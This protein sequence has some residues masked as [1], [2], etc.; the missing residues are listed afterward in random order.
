MPYFDFFRAAELRAAFS[1]PAWRQ[2]RDSLTLRLTIGALVALVAS[3]GVTTWV[4]VRYAEHETE[5]RERDA[6]LSENQAMARVLSRRVLEY[7]RALQLG[8]Q[9]LDANH[10]ASF[11]QID[12]ALK[13]KA[14]LTSMFTNI[15]VADAAG[16]MLAYTD[17]GRIVHPDIDLSERAYF[18]TLLRE[19]R[20]I[21]ST[22]LLGRISGEAS[23]VLAQPLMDGSKVTGV[24]GGVLRLGRRDLLHDITDSLP[25]ADALHPGVFVVVSDALGRILAHPQHDQVGQSLGAERHLDQAFAQWVAM[26]RPLEPTGLNLEQHED[27]VTIA[28][29]PGPDWI[30]WRAYPKDLMHAPLEMARRK[31]WEWTGI[32]SLAFSLMLAAYVAWQLSPLRRLRHRVKNLLDGSMR[33]S[34]GWPHGSGEVGMLSRTLRYVAMELE[35]KAKENHDLIEQLGSVMA[36]APMG[37]AFVRHGWLDMVN[38][39][40]SNL[41]G[42]SQSHLK[43]MRAE[44]LLP[45]GEA[46]MMLSMRIDAAFLAGQS[47]AGDG[48]FLRGDGT[49][50]WGHLKARPVVPGDERAGMIWTLSDVSEQ[51]QSRSRLE[52]SASHDALTGLLNRSALDKFLRIALR[53]RLTRPGA[54]LLIDLDHF[55]PINDR[56]GHLAGD[57]MLQAVSQAISS[58]VRQTDA[59]ARL[60]GDEFAVVLHGCAPE[61]ARILAERVLS[62]ILN[63]TLIWKDGAL[64][65]SA[66]IGLAYLREQ[67][68]S[69]E[70]WIN[71]A[72]QACYA[73]KH[74]G[75]SAVHHFSEGRAE[76]LK[77]VEGRGLS[78]AKLP[79]SQWPSAADAH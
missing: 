74:S 79:G 12:Q 60:G 15:F 28:A 46:W 7:Q 54:L 38:V 73:A 10:L 35:H 57:A 29:V 34:A 53:D 77:W 6:A 36:A 66:S 42:R 13:E 52:W 9:V 41:F 23:I 22:L 4:M 5:I 59:V 56:Q 67:M 50:F 62:S 2:I 71:E 68:S 17:A 14:V 31:A 33:S 51:V 75:R 44:E 21:I 37:L 61:Q 49:V 24:L 32:V 70:D 3:L 11:D 1:R 27:V 64:N 45:S 43:K 65:V 47:F 55:K 39:E 8:A 76:P 40:M 16:R 26:G 63:L 78:T 20:P 19:T 30:V 25:A 69:P 18:Q 72:D 48:E 58:C